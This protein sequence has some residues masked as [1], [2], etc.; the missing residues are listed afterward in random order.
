MK[1]SSLIFALTATSTWG[2]TMN[3]VS[4]TDTQGKSSVTDT[5]GKSSTL[6]V[7][8][9]FESMKAATA[10]IKNFVLAQGIVT[11]NVVPA[12]DRIAPCSLH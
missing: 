4:V 10:H 11:S 9:K 7:E 5:Q 12:S 3:E 6:R 8:M 2:F 1:T